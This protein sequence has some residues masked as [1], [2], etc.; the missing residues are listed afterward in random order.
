MDVYPEAM[1]Y[2]IIIWLNHFMY[3]SIKYRIADI[4]SFPVMNSFHCS[5]AIKML[6]YAHKIEKGFLW[7][8]HKC[9]IK[10]KAFRKEFV[11]TAH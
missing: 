1:Y 5:P 11:I 2:L 10:K 7:M 8:P 6:T 4:S 3:Q 9:T